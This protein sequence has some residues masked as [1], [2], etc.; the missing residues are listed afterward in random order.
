MRKVSSYAELNSAFLYQL[1]K[2]S[3]SLSAS[4]DFDPGAP[5]FVPSSPEIRP[6]SAPPNYICNIYNTEH[7]LFSHRNILISGCDN[8]NITQAIS[9]LHQH[10]YYNISDYEDFNNVRAPF[11]IEYKNA[12]QMIPK[13]HASKIDVWIF[14][15]DDENNMDFIKMNYPYAIVT[16]IL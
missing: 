3:V 12:V 6:Q 13:K 7:S 15:T 1:P 9:K 11:I 16:K 10:N 14:I 4:R 8:M 5:S 2:K